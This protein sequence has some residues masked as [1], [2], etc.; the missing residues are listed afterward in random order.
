MTTETLSGPCIGRPQEMN[1][2]KLIERF[3]DQCAC[4]EHLESVRWKGH[5]HCPYCGSFDVARKKEVGRIGRWNCHD[6]YNSF[7][8]LKGTVMQG[9]RI[10]LRNWFVAIALMVNAKKSISSC[11]LARD[12]D[13]EQ[14]TCWAMQKR[15]RE[16]MADQEI[17]FLEGIVEADETYIGAMP[18][19]GGKKFKGK[20]NKNRRGRGTSKSTIIGVVER[21]GNVVAKRCEDAS[22]HTILELMSACVNLSKS[23][24][25]TD[26]WRGYA[27]MARY[28]PHKILGY[29]KG[30]YHTNTIEGFWSLLKRAWYGQHHHYSVEHMPLYIAEACWKYNN[31]YTDSEEVFDRMINTVMSPA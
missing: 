22:G 15:I 5:A 7:N 29:R 9:T 17:D 26:G 14:K 13:M 20:G 31:R 1:L 4:I 6:C 10:P 24:L 28:M 30:Y 11:Q 21:D 16:A 25:A 2:I 18:R 27:I 3:P 12:L 23:T 8:V 19:M